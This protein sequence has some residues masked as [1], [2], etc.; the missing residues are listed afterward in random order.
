MGKVVVMNHPLIAHKIGIIRNRSTND[1]G[2][3]YANHH[4]Y[5]LAIMSNAPGIMNILE[6]LVSAIDEAHN[7][8]Y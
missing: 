1:A 4:R 3:V 6:P 7:R 8:M 5:I 2:I